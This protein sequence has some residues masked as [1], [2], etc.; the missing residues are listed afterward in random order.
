MYLVDMA[1]FNNKYRQDINDDEEKQFNNEYGSYPGSYQQVQSL[2]PKSLTQTY[3]SMIGGN[4]QDQQTGLKF[5]PINQ[6]APSSNKSGSRFVNIQRYLDQNNVGSAVEKLNKKSDEVI[7]AQEDKYNEGTKAT[8]DWIREGENSEG[9]KFSNMSDLDFSKWVNDTVSKLEKMGDNE[10]EKKILIDRLRKESRARPGLMDKFEFGPESKR[11]LERMSD[12]DQITGELA[13]DKSKYNLGMRNFD[14]ALYGTNREI[15]SSPERFKEQ[16]KSKES[17]L[18]SDLD[19]IKKAR[20]SYI[21][22]YNSGSDRLR[23]ALENERLSL[24]ENAKKNESLIRD[25]DWE[26]KQKEG[27]IDAVT[28]KPLNNSFNPYS[29]YENMTLQIQRPNPYGNTN[30]HYYVDPNDQA[31]L[32]DPEWYLLNNAATDSDMRTY[33]RY[34]NYNALSDILGL[35]M[36]DFIGKKRKIN[37]SAEEKLPPEVRRKLNARDDSVRNNSRKAGDHTADSGEYSPE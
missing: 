12:L 24:I 14:Q 32:D 18:N 2:I 36:D 20:Q 28:G 23:K 19:A 6:Q 5:N 7:K 8:K 27:G 13:S 26:E 17:Y 31:Y 30:S 22:K 9:Y 25:S 29:H 37:K 4:Q 15:L 35:S 3:G 21:D 34:K 1:Y 10:P 11:F 33:K 16:F